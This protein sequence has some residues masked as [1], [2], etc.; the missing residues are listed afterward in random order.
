MDVYVAFAKDWKRDYNR[1]QMGVGRRITDDDM[2]KIKEKVASEFKRV[3]T[4]ELTSGGYQV[5]DENAADVMLLRPAIIN[6]EVTAP[7]LPSVGMTRTIVRSTGSMTLYAELYDSVTSEKFAE[8]IDAEEVG[9]HSFAHEANR[10]TN[11]AELD[12][13]LASWANILRKRL[14]EAHQASAAGS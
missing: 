11:Q 3:F 2:E 7:D 4:K 12:R 10:G 1:E 5:V 6:L 13:T 14:D 8:V 9:G